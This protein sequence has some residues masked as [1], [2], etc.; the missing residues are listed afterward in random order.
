MGS[1]T[2]TEIF[3]IVEFDGLK[4]LAVQQPVAERHSVDKPPAGDHPHHGVITADLH[5]GCRE[6][7]RKTQ[8]LAQPVMYV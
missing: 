5:V 1:V 3:H 4:F 7:R 8:I 2:K 6:R